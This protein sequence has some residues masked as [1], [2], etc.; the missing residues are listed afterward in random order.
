MKKSK[1]LVTKQIAQ[2]LGELNKLSD[3]VASLLQID[4]N[5]HTLWVSM[6]R[7][8]LLLMTDDSSFATQLRFQQALIQQHINQ[9]LLTKVKEVKIKV[10]AAKPQAHEQVKEKCFRISSQTTNVLSYI[11]EDIDEELRESLRRLGR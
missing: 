1:Q 11:A 10:I 4:R 6:K 7:N 3:S 8:K 2:H 5:I 9:Q